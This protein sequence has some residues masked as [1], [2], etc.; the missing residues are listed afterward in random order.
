MQA[1]SG[2]DSVPES[3]RQ[4]AHVLCRHGDPD[5]LS[6]KVDR[7]DFLILVLALGIGVET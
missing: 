5:S 4:S 2:S 6:Q 3:R 7:N 1:D